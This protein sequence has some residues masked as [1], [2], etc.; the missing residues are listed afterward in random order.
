MIKKTLLC[1]FLENMHHIPDTFWQK[2]DIKRFRIVFLLSECCYYSVI[3]EENFQGVY[4]Y[5][6]SLVNTTIVKNCKFNPQVTFERRCLLDGMVAQWEDLMKDTLSIPVC[7]FVDET[8][9][10][11]KDLNDLS[12][13]S[14][15]CVGFLI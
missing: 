3:G 11:L 5:P 6:T 4:E 2:R 7:A 10:E 14:P 13:V 9:E 1:K 12:E 8:V 15:T